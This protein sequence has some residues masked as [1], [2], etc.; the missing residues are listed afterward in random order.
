MDGVL[1]STRQRRSIIT[2]LI[3]S[4]ASTPGIASA[5]AAI[6]FEKDMHNDKRLLLTY[7]INSAVSI[8]VSKGLGSEGRLYKA[9]P[10][11]NTDGC[12]PP[13]TIRSGCMASST[14]HPSLRNS[15]I[16]HICMPLTDS[17]A[18]SHNLAQITF[19]VVP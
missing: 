11:S 19:L 5:I 17:P 8:F 6:S 12:H 16:M 3:T 4:C 7:L 13:I 2:P 14:A 9:R 18:S 1:E 15:G 10:I